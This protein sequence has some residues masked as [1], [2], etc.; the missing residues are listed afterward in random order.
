MLPA[1][2]MHFSEGGY[3]NIAIK[4]F[5]KL[6]VYCLLPFSYIA[7]ITASNADVYYVRLHVNYQRANVR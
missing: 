5:T 1:D 2:G 3:D 6:S 4:L 7:D